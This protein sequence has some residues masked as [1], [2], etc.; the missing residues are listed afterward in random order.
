MEQL[1]HANKRESKNNSQIAQTI[2]VEVSR[3]SRVCKYYNLSMAFST[4][5]IAFLIE[6]TYL[7][8]I[9]KVDALK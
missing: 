9:L 8:L 1:K 5:K 2:Y 4:L 6:V 7:A 3:R